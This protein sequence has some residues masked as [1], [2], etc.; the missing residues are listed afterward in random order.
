MQ[1]MMTHKFTEDTINEMDNI[2]YAST[3]KNSKVQNIGDNFNFNT[4]SP[5][6]D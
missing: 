3:M 4:G 6:R 2:P 1:K 5:E